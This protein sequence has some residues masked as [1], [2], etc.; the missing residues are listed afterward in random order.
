M[1]QPALELD[2]ILA[3]RYSDKEAADLK[4]H[5]KSKTPVEE[6][7]VYEAVSIKFEK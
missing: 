3:A 1:Q 6:L 7:A 2:N 5:S 4:C